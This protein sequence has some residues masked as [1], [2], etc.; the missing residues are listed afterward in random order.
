LE[1]VRGGR[2][3]FENSGKQWTPSD[4]PPSFWKGPLRYGPFREAFGHRMIFVYGTKGSAEENDW[5]VAKSR[6]DAESWWYRGN[7]S[8][9]VMPDVEF[10]PTKEPD[11]G[12]VLYGNA[13]NN[14]AWTTLLADSPVQVRRGVLEVGSRAFRGDSLACLFC[15]PRRGSD[16]ACVAVVSGTGLVG[17]RLTDRTPYLSAGIAYPDCTVFGVE[18]LSQG[19]AG[20]RAAGFFGNDW[21]VETGDFVWRN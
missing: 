19:T 10:D 16:R 2:V 21:K 5:A 15:R 6:F 9:D 12:V 14:S 4:A 13:N 18:T 11:R 3:W 8:V 7:G 1:K 17:L 20:V